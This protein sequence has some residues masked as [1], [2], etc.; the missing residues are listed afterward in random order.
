MSEA[1]HG[2][3]RRAQL[4]SPRLRRLRRGVVSAAF[5]SSGHVTTSGG[6]VQIKGH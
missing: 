6:S 4:Q 3:G 2:G 1:N 5:F